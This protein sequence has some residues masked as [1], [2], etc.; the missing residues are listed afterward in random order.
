MK[1]QIIRACDIPS[2]L[3]DLS[4]HNPP[5]IQKNAV[6]S[7]AL[8]S[9]DNLFKAY[10]SIRCD[11]DKWR[12]FV[13]I[14]KK[15]D[16]PNNERLLS[17]LFE[18]LQDI[19]WPGAQESVEYLSTLNTDVLFPLLKEYIRTAYNNKDTMWLGGLKLLTDKVYGDEHN[20]PDKTVYT[21]LYDADF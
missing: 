10:Q 11:K 1:Q 8:F 3:Y 20:F 19:N 16:Y 12:N 7:L 18:L 13:Y 15:I 17:I 4:W 5:N 6:N 2:L 21:M 14:I 9:A